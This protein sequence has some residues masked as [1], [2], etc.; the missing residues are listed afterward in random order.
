[1]VITDTRLVYR[2]LLAVDVER[3]SARN[4]ME[5]LQAQSDLRQTLEEA[6]SRS[7]LDR[8]LWHKQVRG[9]GELAVLPPEVDVPQVAGTFV[10]RL[11]TALADL[12]AAHVGRSPL[13]LRLALH[14]GTLAPGPFGPIGDAPI[15]VSRLL[16]APAL[17]RL[18][19]ER[20][21]GDLAVVVSDA[22]FQD[23]VRTGFCALGPAD[24]A[25]I[26]ITAKGICYRGHVRRSR[27]VSADATVLDLSVRRRARLS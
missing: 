21:D 18:L 17:R 1:M 19:A 24:F 12:N 5:Q 11:E 15:V 16:D 6:A 10:R 7:G 4:A 26:R 3:Y 25:P 8:G 27:V 20:Q 22:L 2:L 9:D 13:R 14:H 23:V